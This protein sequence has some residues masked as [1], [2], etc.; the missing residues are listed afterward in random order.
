MENKSIS[1]KGLALCVKKVLDEYNHNE[2]FSK[3]V[4]C[5]FEE[6]NF[7]EIESFISVLGNIDYKFNISEL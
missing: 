6:I 4:G 1:S 7:N 5:G 2:E 3:L